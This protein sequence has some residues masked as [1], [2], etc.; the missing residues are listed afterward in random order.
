MP[1]NNRNQGRNRRQGGRR[2]GGGPR[3]CRDCNEQ[4]YEGKGKG[5]TNRRCPSNAGQQ[6]PVQRPPVQRPPVQQ[7]VQQLVQQPTDLVFNPAPGQQPQVVVIQV[8]HHYATAPAPGFAPEPF[9]F[10]PAPVSGALFG[11]PAPAAGGFRFGPPPAVGGARPYVHPQR[12]TG[13]FLC[14]CAACLDFDI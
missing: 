8:H 2:D 11:P 13:R 4:T 12:C 3:Q 6:P 1:R 9:R 5:C 14:D 7:P 10:G